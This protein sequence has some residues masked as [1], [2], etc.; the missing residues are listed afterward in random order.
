[1]SIDEIIIGC[2]A[3][4]RSWILPAWKKAVD[5]ATI[6]LNVSYVF[7]VPK[8]DSECLDLVSGWAST[9]ILATDEAPRRDIRDWSNTDRYYHMSEIRN[10]VLKYVRQTKP[11]L[12][13]SL[14][15]DILLARD[16]LNDMTETL[17][18]NG[19]D[20]VG[21]ATFL[22]SV[23]PTVTNV[24]HLED[25][26]KFRRVIPGQHQIDIIM[27]VKL[28]N[29]RAYNVDYEWHQYGEDFGWSIAAAK[30]GCKIFCDGRT[31]SK[32]VMGPEW[33]DRIDKRVG[34]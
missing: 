12:F 23:D 26:G 7:A 6:G 9:H 10:T 34:Y 30:A 5:A 16:A 11:S 22:D 27:A 14:D 21:G 24:A 19:A 1:M 33:L 4:G 25:S 31:P 20:A 17:V 29:E 15:S 13:L 28:M 18:V 3:A 32:H 8:W 2:P